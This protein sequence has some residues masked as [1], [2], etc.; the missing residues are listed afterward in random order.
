MNK[1]FPNESH[2]YQ[3]IEL[4]PPSLG[5]EKL[6]EDRMPSPGGNCNT[7]QIPESVGR[8]P[9]VNRPTDQPGGDPNNV[10]KPISF[11]S[12]SEFMDWEPPEGFLLLG[13]G[14]RSYLARGGVAVLS[15]HPGTFKS[16]ASI[17]IA[18][19]AALNRRSALGIP[20]ACSFKTMVLQSENGHYRFNQEFNQLADV[21][22]SSRE[23]ARAL[24]DESIRVSEIPPLGIDFQ[25]PG[26]RSSLKREIENF[27]PGLLVIDPWNACFTGEGNQRDYGEALRFIMGSLPENPEKRPGV[28][29]V[30]HCR[31]GN[32][33]SK[34]F[35]R[36]MLHEIAGSL[37]LGSRA[38]TV[39]VMDHVS[40][41]QEVNEVVLFNAKANDA[42]TLPPVAFETESGQ[43]RQ[44]EFDYDEYCSQSIPGERKRKVVE[45]GDIQL[46]LGN[47]ELKQSAI[48][49]RVIE[50]AQEDGRKA[51][52]KTTVK[53]LITKLKEEGKI[54]LDD[55]SFLSWNWNP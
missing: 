21:L 8:N 54:S 49:G 53:E 11:C 23:E 37:Q 5:A 46:A 33:N 51:P 24:F 18:I 16:R 34:S 7:L 35:G 44:V 32:K 27:D 38:R 45:P 14:D 15:G 22:F 30:A 20:L 50:R 1:H 10:I 43:F 19:Q 42:P 25:N 13:D 17:F 6:L 29:I 4:E 48:I 41:D 28:L 12:P 39:F 31:K 9:K 3:P 55:D 36:D 2:N 26:F 52:G 47:E 40:A